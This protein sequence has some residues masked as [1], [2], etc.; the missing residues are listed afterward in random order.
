MFC[1][2]IRL[3]TRSFLQIILLVKDS[4]QQQIHFN[5]NI[6]GYKCCRCNDGSLYWNNPFKGNG[7]TW[8]KATLPKLFCL[9]SEIGFTLNEKKKMFS[10]STLKGKN[11]L[12]PRWQVLFFSSGLFYGIY[13]KRKHVSKVHKCPRPFALVTYGNNYLT[14]AQSDLL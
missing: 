4:L 6:F 12:F 3:K 2:E 11:L 9:P 10:M 14:N 13:A 5:G 8:G 1:D 7:Y